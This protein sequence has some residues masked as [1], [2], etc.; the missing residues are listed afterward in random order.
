MDKQKLEIIVKTTLSRFT[1]KA[2]ELQDLCP[3]MA[4]EK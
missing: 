4:C 1:D 2:D 3:G